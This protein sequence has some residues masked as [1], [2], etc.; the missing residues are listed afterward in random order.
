MS[1]YWRKTQLTSDFLHQRNSI[2]GRVAGFPFQPTDDTTR[3]EKG[4]ETEFLQPPAANL[5]ENR[6]RVLGI[7]LVRHRLYVKE[8]EPV[9]ASNFTNGFGEFFQVA[10]LFV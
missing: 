7:Q 5:R 9:S 8:S 1:P 3:V 4:F 10:L 6:L 2:S